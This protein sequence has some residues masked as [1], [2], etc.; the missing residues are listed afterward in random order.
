MPF[1]LMSRYLAPG[2]ADSVVC[3]EARGAYLAT[4]HLVEHGLRR[5][6]YV[7]GSTVVFSSEQRIKGFLDACADAG[8]PEEDRRVWVLSDRPAS[9][10]RR[11]E[12]WR[13][14]IRDSPRSATGRG[15]S[16]TGS[17]RSRGPRR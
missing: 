14:R 1:V 12:A 13:R 3:D 4:M 7:S 15:A 10:R 16:P 2:E 9:P 17:A 5:L 8:I 6:A 11:G